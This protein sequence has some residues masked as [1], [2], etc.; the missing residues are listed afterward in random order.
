MTRNARHEP[1]VGGGEC[2]WV[3]ERGWV[4]LFYGEINSRDRVHACFY[5]IK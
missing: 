2:E 4:G 5:I 3:G 1:E